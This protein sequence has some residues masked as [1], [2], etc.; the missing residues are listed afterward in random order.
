VAVSFAALNKQTNTGTEA[1][2]DSNNRAVYRH[3]YP[4]PDSW[5]P[6]RVHNYC[7]S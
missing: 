2:H 1:Q 7:T 6:I 3:E 5:E 4:K